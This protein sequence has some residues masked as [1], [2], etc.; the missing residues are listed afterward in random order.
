MNDIA[1]LGDQEMLRQAEMLMQDASLQQICID[2]IDSVLEYAVGWQAQSAEIK[3]LHKWNIASDIPDVKDKTY[4]WPYLYI[5]P[6][7]RE[8]GD[9]DA[10]TSNKIDDIIDS[11][12]FKYFQSLESKIALLWAILEDIVIPLYQS[13]GYDIEQWEENT[14]VS[15]V[16]SIKC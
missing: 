5:H 1:Q 12:N 14:E 3:I 16:F 2:Y 10:R 6:V 8:Y 15:K 4:I 11:Y 13:K 7:N 9:E